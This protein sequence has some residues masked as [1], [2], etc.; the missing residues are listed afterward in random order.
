MKYLEVLYKICVLLAYTPTKWKECKV[1]FIP[2]PGKDTY[3]AAKS[4]RPISLTNYLLKT[5]EKICSW[6]MDEM[7]E[8][9]PVH[10]RQHGFRSDRNTETSL[11]DVANY[12]EKFIY[13]GQHVIGVFLDIQAAFDTID[14]EKV[15]TSLIEHG[16][17]EDLVDWYYHYIT[18]RNLH[19]QIKGCKKILSTDT[20]SP[21]GGVCSAKFWIIAFNEAIEILNT[22]GVHGNGFADDCVAL[23]G[24]ENLD[25]IMSQMQKVVTKLEPWGTKYGLVFNPSKTEVIIFSK[26]QRIERRAPNRLIVGSQNINFTTQAKYLGVILDN[27]LLW[28]KYIDHATKRAKQFIFTLKKAV[29]KKWGPKPKYMKWAYTAIVKARLFY[30]CLV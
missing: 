30:G 8:T 25:Q 20:G 4:W 13:N 3:D 12:I 6:H 19:V 5:L 22:H 9:Y 18:H 2:K 27:K 14:P 21:Q 7:L 23:I 24:G 26:A 15:K 29:S 11:S 28:S 1:V 16:G 10:I 17:D